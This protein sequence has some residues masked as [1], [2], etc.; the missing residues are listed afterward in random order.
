MLFTTTLSQVGI[1]LVYILLGYFLSKAKVIDRSASKVLS[2]LLTMVFLPCYVVVNLIQ[3]ASI[4]NIT[5]Y[6]ALILSGL[7]FIVVA[8]FLCNPIAKKLGKSKLEKNCYLYMI[9][10]GNF[11]YL[12]YPLVETVFGAEANIQFILFCLPISIII[13]SYGYILLTDDG[14]NNG[15]KKAFDYK[16]L[17]SPPV[18][19]VVIGLILG[20]LPIEMPKIV[21]NVLSPAKACMSPIAMIMAGIVLSSFSFKQL[22]SSVKAYITS[23]ITLIL[24]PLFFGGL[25]YALCKFLPI[26]KEVFVMVASFCALP[27]GMN[28]VVFPESVGHDGSTGARTSFCAYILSIITLPI[29]FNLIDIL[30]ATL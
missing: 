23:G 8:Y 12:G 14:E 30:T 20:L 18:L 2:K 22:F 27:A 17:L 10:I 7:I 1:F 28:V 5:T 24:L 25:T 6:F 26:P 13:H 4:E 15:E 11:G 3:H 19:A 21:L 16:T 9:I 29:M